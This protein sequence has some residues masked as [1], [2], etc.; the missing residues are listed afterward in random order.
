MDEFVQ[1]IASICKRYRISPL[2]AVALLK[3]RDTG[4]GKRFIQGMSIAPMKQ[5]LP[6]VQ[7]PKP[8]TFFWDE[9]DDD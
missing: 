8:T 3:W 5:R 2:C 7:K 9:V 6:R 1:T 4:D